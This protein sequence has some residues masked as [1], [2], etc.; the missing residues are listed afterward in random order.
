MAARFTCQF[1]L[2]TAGCVPR[3]PGV[4]HPRGGDSSGIG[5]LHQTRDDSRRRSLLPCIF[6][7]SPVAG[8]DA[9][10][11]R[12]LA[13]L[14]WLAPSTVIGSAFHPRA[15]RAAAPDGAI[16]AAQFQH[17]RARTAGNRQIA[18]VPAGLSVCPPN[19]RRQGD[20]GPH[21]RQQRHRSARPGGPVRRRV[22]RR[23]LW[24]LLRPE[25]WRQHHEGL[26]GVRGVL[27]WEGVDP[28]RRLDRA[29][30]ELRRR[31]GPP[32]AHRAPVLGTS[33]RN[34]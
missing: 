14:A 25:G 23:D 27:P 3:V 10:A 5:H 7:V 6:P 12:A 15:G 33:S 24:R 21:V 16:C 22:L 11:G 34:A 31:C 29:R 13:R 26:H 32:A 4:L 17:G 8:N 30:R 18:P 19:L 20:G 1:G 2:S 9:P 28:G